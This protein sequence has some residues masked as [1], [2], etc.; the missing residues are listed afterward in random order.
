[1]VIHDCIHRSKCRETI[2]W[3]YSQKLNVAEPDISRINS[4]L[5]AFVPAWVEKIAGLRENFIP[6]AVQDYGPREDC[7]HYIVMVGRPLYYATVADTP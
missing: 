7:D 3:F 5:L 4:A 1:M 6:L 2:D